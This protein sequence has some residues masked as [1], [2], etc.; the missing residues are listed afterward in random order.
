MPQ[1][2]RST[3]RRGLAVLGALAALLLLSACGDD[4]EAD[5]SDTTAADSTEGGTDGGSD[6]SDAMGAVEGTEVTIAGYAFAPETLTAHTGD[7]VVWTNE[8]DFAHRVSS[9]TDAW[10]PSE[11][12]ST[13]GTFEVP[14]D[15]AGTYAYHCGIHNY[16]TG[17]IVVE[18]A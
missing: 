4:D 11:D 12:I 7:T 5:T 15:E 9:D 13:G 2:L 1:H 10:E 17:V 16:M 6:T 14:F 18:D 8:D 3:S